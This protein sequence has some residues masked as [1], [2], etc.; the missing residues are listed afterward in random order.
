MHHN[1]PAGGTRQASLTHYLC[2]TPDG[3]WAEFL[4]HEELRDPQDLPT[5]RR[6]LWVIDI[7]EIPLQ[8]PGCVPAIEVELPCGQG[9]HQPL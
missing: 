6:T 5:V 3:A 2:D 9:K 8:A 1:P 7:G 4:R